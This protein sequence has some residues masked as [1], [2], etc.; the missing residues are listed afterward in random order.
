M[1]LFSPVPGISW[2]R[3]DGS[4]LPGKAKYSKSQATLEIPNFQQEDEGFYE[5]TAGNLRGRNR[6]KGR[7]VFYGELPGAQRAG[8]GLGCPTATRAGVGALREPPAGV[9][10]GAWRSAG[11][12]ALL[13]SWL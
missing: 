7:L 1:Y 11:G 3:L 6:A 12:E 2:R 4:P 13:K 5:C 10:C 8:G 9:G